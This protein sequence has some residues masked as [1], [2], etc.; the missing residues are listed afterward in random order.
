MGAG[1][2]IGFYK[3]EGIF[4]GGPQWFA[5]PNGYNPKM[6]MTLAGADNKTIVS[7]NLKNTKAKVWTGA[8]NP[9]VQGLSAVDLRA[10]MT[11][12]FSDNPG[13]FNAFST[14]GFDRDVWIPNPA[15]RTVT[16][17]FRKRKRRVR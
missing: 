17:K 1:G 13:M 7:D 4:R 6:T 11:V 2:E 16:V 3:Q 12:D 15:R 8:W 10:T 14:S 9:D 5:D